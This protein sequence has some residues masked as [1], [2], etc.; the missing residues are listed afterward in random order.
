MSEPV[1]ISS[2]QVARGL[3][4]PL[5][6]IESVIKLLDE[7]FPVPFI[8]RYRKDQTGNLDETQI[9]DIESRLNELRQLAERKQ[10]ILKAIESL[11]KLTPE[12][13]QKIREARTS[14][15]LE[16]LYLPY[17]PKRETL[18]S[19]ARSRGLEPLALEILEGKLTQEQL[20][21]RVKDF[22]D[23]DKGVKTEADALLGAGHIIGELFSER[24]ELR[25]KIRDLIQRTSKLVSKRIEQELP[26]GEIGE[27]PATGKASPIVV[28]E[29]AQANAATSIAA[30]FDLSG[31]SDPFAETNVAPDSANISETSANA[32]IEVVAPIVSD[33]IQPVAEAEIVSTT[34][35]LQSVEAEKTADVIVSTDTGPITEVVETSV[36][37]VDVV[38]DVI[39]SCAGESDVNVETVTAVPVIDAPEALQTVTQDTIAEVTDA[40]TDVSADAANA[41]TPQNAILP[42]AIA[43]A[44]AVKAEKKKNKKK[45]KAKTPQEEK[46]LAELEKLYNDY[47]DFTSELRKMMPYRVLAINRGE[48]AKVLR[49][50]FDHDKDVIEKIVGEYCVP[51]DHPLATFLSECAKDALQRLLLPALEREARRDL[52]ESAEQQAINVFTKNLRNLLL[53]PPLNRQRVLAI[54]PGLRHGCKMVALDEFGNVLAYETVYLVGKAGKKGGAAETVI[55]LINKFGLTVIAIGNGTGCREAEDFV[56]KLI[57]GK[58]AG[59]DVGYIVVNEAGA[60]IY[61][62]SPAA[63][64]EFPNYDAMLRGAVSI[65]RRLQDPLNELVKIDPGH[66]GV[67]MYQHDLKAKHLQD[68]LGKVVESCVNHVGVDL[69]RAT[70]AILRYVAGLNQLT[71]RRIYE[72]RQEH[73]PFRTREQLKDVT[74]MGEVSYTHAAGFLKIK[75]GASPLDATW[76]HPE[77]YDA[78]VK[79]LR[80]FGFEEGD[81]RSNDKLAQIA[82]SLKTA[83]AADL[84]QEL[85]LGQHT[86]GDIIAQ[87]GRPGRDPREE[88]PPPV[89]KKGVLNMADLSPGTEL[90]GTVLNVVDFG[91]FVDIGLHESGLVHISQM[92]DRYVKDAHDLVSV[93]DVVKVWVV[94]IDHQR[95]RISLTML[96]PGTERKQE[97]REDQRKPRGERSETGD[98]PRREGGGQ[99]GGQRDGQRNNQRGGQGGTQGTGQQGAQSGGQGTDRQGGDRPRRDDRRND[100]RGGSQGGQRSG[101][102]RGDNREGGR[103]DGGGRGQGRRDGDRRTDRFNKPKSFEIP[104][105]QEK[106]IT[107]LSENMK[108][109]SEPLRSFSDLA[110]LLGHIKP[111]DPAEEKRRKKEEKQALAQKRRAEEAAAQQAEQ[112]AAGSDDT[113]VDTNSMQVETSSK[114]TD[115]SQE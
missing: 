6:K 48:K 13:D 70:P 94:E 105:K 63:K 53:Q 113:P 42:P 4:I 97:N 38:Q 100:Q 39:V 23:A 11:G 93:G 37:G 9:R 96:P 16:D 45:K 51:S 26:E 114:Q 80:K 52:T 82:E 79:I 29:S 67:G 28:T 83:D 64:E 1:T 12:L 98:R 107:P 108:K 111:V 78:A 106:V 46:R 31:S 41:G 40:T 44:K 19:T 47:F 10:V 43:T 109:G 68:S 32:A 61:S 20:D 8:A 72:Y 102:Q 110:Q 69:N 85:G 57:D 76:I 101:G 3:E 99:R 71:A 77:S 30:K 91:A 60:S 90:T 62:A 2:K 87:L 75:D 25:Q 88:L 95:K 104:S 5:E 92:A 74:G 7:G 73:G 36:A 81:L 59:G 49:I 21:Q 24:V 15:R 84:S 33:V 18:A 50:K 14:K 103:G 34:D 115:N 86:V 65:G 112:T 89:F 35:E 56:G 17:K 66:L 54:D 22:V 27:T 58:Q 55:G